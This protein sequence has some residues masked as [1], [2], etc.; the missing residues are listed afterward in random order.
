MEH[1]YQSIRDK[2]YKTMYKDSLMVMNSG[3]T[4]CNNNLNYSDLNRVF[5]LDTPLK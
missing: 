5:Q 3:F 2:I 4:E 1:N